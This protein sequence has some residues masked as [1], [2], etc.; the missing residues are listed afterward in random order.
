ML[1]N[2]EYN[3]FPIILLVSPLCLVLQ[4]QVPAPIIAFDAAHHDFGE[5]SEDQKIAHR[6][7]VTNKGNSPLNVKEVRTSCDCTD[8]AIG[9]MVLLPGEST[10]IEVRFN[11]E[12]LQGKVRRTL[13][14]ISDDPATPISKLSFDADVIREIMPS[15]DTVIFTKINRD[16]AGLASIRLQSGNDRAITVTRASALNAPYI[17]CEPQQDGNDVILNIVIKGKLI[18]MDKNR[19]EDVLTVHTENKKYSTMQFKI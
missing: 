15:G 9:K 5:I 2:P 16:G 4:S 7:I 11:P 8:T 13:D 1:E 17:S 10:F 19:G 14:V 18:P 3:M 6:Y 12:G